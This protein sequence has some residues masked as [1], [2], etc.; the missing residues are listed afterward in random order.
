MIEELGSFEVPGV[1]P[2]EI[3]IEYAS[4][5]LTIKIETTSR[6]GIYKYYHPHMDPQ[7]IEASLDLGILKIT[8]QKIKS[9]QPVKIQVGKPKL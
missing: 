4:N 9:Q 7:S 8:G 2:E 3:S 1:K 6:K 5:T